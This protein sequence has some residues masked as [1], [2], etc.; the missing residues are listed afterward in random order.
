[1][2]QMESEST[3]NSRLHMYENSSRDNRISIGNNTDHDQSSSYHGKTSQLEHAATTHNSIQ[4]ISTTTGQTQVS[5]KRQSFKSNERVGKGGAPSG[6]KVVTL[7]SAVKPDFSNM[8]RQPA[9]TKNNV[10]KQLDGQHIIMGVSKKTITDSLAI[11]VI[12][13]KM[14]LANTSNAGHLS[15][16]SGK[17]TTSVNQ[18]NYINEASLLMQ[19]VSS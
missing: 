6:L 19:A 18:G 4:G 10:K 11:N 12:P 16:R 13:Q 2:Q 14:M 17:G 8:V 9:S 15:T 1:M 5:N 3:S 7:Q